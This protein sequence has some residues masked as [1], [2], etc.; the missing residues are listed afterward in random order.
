MKYGIAAQLLSFVLPVTVLI[1]VP[2]GIL[3]GTGEYPLG[4]GL[5]LVWDIISIAAGVALMACGLF[6][7]SWTI[8]L[9]NNIGKGTL[10]PWSPTSKL[11]AIGPYRYVRNPMINGV[12]ITLLGETLAFGSFGLLIWFLTFFII[13]HIYFIVSEEPGL[14]KRFGD[15]YL[16]YKKNVPCWIPRLK[17]WEG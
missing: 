7:L 16:E 8:Q 1:I 10:A 9:F 5:P 12:L 13:N 15:S 17:P 14:V 4:W 11:V 2:A 6:L 3:R